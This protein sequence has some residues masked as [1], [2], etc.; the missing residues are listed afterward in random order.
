MTDHPLTAPRDTEEL[1]ERLSAVTPAV[2]E[3][4]RR[5]DGDLLFLGAGGKMGPTLARMARRACEQGGLTKRVLA[6]S[7]FSSPGLAERLRSWGIE[8]VPCDLLDERQVAQL[9]AAANV[10]FMTG[11]KFGATANPG[12]TW[13]MNCLAPAHVCHQ[14][15]R[16]RLAVFSS[17][18]IYGVSPVAR[19]GSL[20]DDALNPIGE[21]AMTVLGRERI[22]EYFSRQRGLP[23]VV[24]RLNY[25]TELRYGVLVDIGRRVHA[26]QP[27]DLA[28]GWVNVIWQADANAA[29][30]QALTLAASPPR[31]LNLAG[32]EMLRVREVA[33][34][35]GK[36]MHKRVEFQ[37]SE[38]AD[39]LLNNASQC[40]RL[41]G[42]PAVSADQVIRWTADWIQR[43]GEYL[44]KPTHFERRDGK[45]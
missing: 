38:G 26:G 21:Y 3:S 31:I 5:L 41:F 44:G 8:P 4:L 9:P 34:R 32:P 43:G 23:V 40:H 35:F 36:L 33:E 15:A 2:V 6:A 14:F 12:L 37:G 45:F 10:F 22:F 39:A 11:M 25:A 20:E 42:Q 19:G 13:A 28:M 29:A 17:G 24:L 16:S 27:V 30:L 1:E 7:R 18:N